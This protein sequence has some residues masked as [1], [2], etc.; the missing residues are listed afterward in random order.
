MGNRVTWRE[1]RSPS[2]TELHKHLIAKRQLAHRPSQQRNYHGC[3]FH[4]AAQGLKILSLV[5]TPLLRFRKLG[6]GRDILGVF[7][8]WP[9]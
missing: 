9:H 7:P 5:T 8:H 4:P 1:L 2:P 3:E 6:P